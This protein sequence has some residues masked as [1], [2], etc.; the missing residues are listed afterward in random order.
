MRI[1]SPDDLQANCIRQLGLDCSA[2]DL[3]SPEAL[4]ELLR[5][6]SAFSCPCSPSK[7]VSVAV[8]LLEPLDCVH[9]LRET[10][11]DTLEA[12]TAYGDLIESND[13]T[14]ESNS[15]AIYLA[16]PSFVEV[17]PTLFLL[18]GG[19]PDGQYPLPEELTTKVEPTAHYRR[20]RVTDRFETT[21]ALLQ[22]GFL[23]VKPDA[24]LKTPP[25]A[26]PTIHIAPY[27]SALDQ[28]G[29]AGTIDEIIVLDRSRPVG[30]YRGR[31]GKLKKQSGRFL[32]RR[33]Q[34][35]GA[36]LWCYVKVH[37]GVVSQLLD[38]PYRE[39]RWRPCDEAW[40]LQQAIDASAGTSQLYRLR[41]GSSIS[42]TV[43]DLFSP[44]PQW[45]TRRWDYVGTRVMSA[46]CLFSY[47]FGDD[48]IKAELAFAQERM[49]LRQ[50]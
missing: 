16:P 24:W 49:W 38:L 33:P 4:S 46:G 21:E 35:Y 41:K 45:A 37:D 30:Y 19:G 12:L 10:I 27:D 11:A 3:S 18:I 48:H 44:V 20:L 23:A 34:A 31:W 32:A 42:S 50:Q 9:P 14:G 15:R 26:A 36:D 43:V 8:E 2:L 25:V 28:S 1:L 47:V 7:L 40:H 5:R 17:T 13:I 39:T 22:A 29:P 6:I